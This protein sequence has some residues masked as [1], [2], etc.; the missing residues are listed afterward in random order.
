MKRPCFHCKEHTEQYQKLIGI[1]F[2]WVCAKCNK[3]A[4]TSK[5]A[6]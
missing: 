5:L 4:W 2:Y 6:L 1:V 3:V